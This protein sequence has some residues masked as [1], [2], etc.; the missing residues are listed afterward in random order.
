MRKK[1]FACG[2][3]FI[4]KNPKLD[5][6]CDRCRGR[7]TEKDNNAFLNMTHN[8]CIAL[9]G[10]IL[11]QAG[12][13]YKQLI[14]RWRRSDESEEK[15]ILYADIIVFSRWWKKG[16]KQFGE[17]LDGCKIQMMLNKSLYEKIRDERIKQKKA[18]T[19]HKKR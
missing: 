17:N 18:E 5:L 13:D 12:D 8:D 14:R 1:C 9:V 15:K 3:T 10:A 2:K 4:V 11:K 16:F 6:Y 7:E 19:K